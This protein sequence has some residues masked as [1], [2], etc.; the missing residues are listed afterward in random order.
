MLRPVAFLMGVEW[1]DC[2]VV[3]ELLGIKTFLNEFVAYA[4]LSDFIK[5]RTTENGLRT[6][7]VSH[8]VSQF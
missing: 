7:S 8:I 1:K 5:N 6:I 4:K 3:A 2:D